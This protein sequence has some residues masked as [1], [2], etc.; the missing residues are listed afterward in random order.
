MSL[1]LLLLTSDLLEGCTSELL[2]TVWDLL[3]MLVFSPLDIAQDYK[4]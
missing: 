4:H 1:P 2:D 3:M